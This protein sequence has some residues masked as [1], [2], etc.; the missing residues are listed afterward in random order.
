MTAGVAIEIAA[1]AIAPCGDRVLV[2]QDIPPE[3]IGVVVVPENV[4]VPG[5][6]GTVIAV[7]PEACEFHEGDRVMVGRYT[8]HQVEGHKDLMLLRAEDILAMVK[9]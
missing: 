3:K 2:R 6:I 9:T 4:R 5:T 8:G 7:G 1:D